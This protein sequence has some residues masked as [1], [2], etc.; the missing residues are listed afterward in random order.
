M[1]ARQMPSAEDLRKLLDYNPATGQLFWRPRLDGPYRFNSR[2]AGQEAGC[3]S[4]GDGYRTVSIG[5]KRYYSHRIIWKLVHGVEPIF[6]DHIDGDRLNNR[7][8]N[9]RSVTEAE[10]RRNACINSKNTSGIT[11]VAPDKKHGGWIARIKINGANRYIGKFYS[12][13]EAAAAR[14]LAERAHGFH[15]NHGRRA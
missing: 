1:A 10:N 5:K 13:D 11:G 2:Y 4:S 7:L 12:L 8:F 15:P 6:I 3:V 14:K 9:L